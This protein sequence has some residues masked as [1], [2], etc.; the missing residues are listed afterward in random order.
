MSA[1]SLSQTVAGWRSRHEILFLTILA[2]V[3]TAVY[4][5]MDVLTLH[6]YIVAT[7]GLTAVFAYLIVGSWTGTI[8]GVV[9]AY[10][11]GK[12]LVD[13]DF[14]GMIFRNR[15]MHTSAAVAGL[16][17]SVSTL[18]FLWGS[19]LGDPG[20]VIALGNL[21]I[22]NTAIWDWHRKQVSLRTI[23]LPLALSVLGGG[24]AVYGGSMQAGLLAVLF[25]V[26]IS[27]GLGTISEIVEQ[28]G[29]R[30]SD[31]VNFFIWR[32][33][34]L[35]LTGTSLAFIVSIT[36]GTLPLLIAT[37]GQATTV[38]PW[39]AL[40]MLFVFM[41]ISLKL[42]AKK[43]GAISIVLIVMSVQVILGYVFT[44]IGNLVQPGLFGQLP[45]DPVVWL[46]RIAGGVLI[47]WGI[48]CIKKV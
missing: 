8:C 10:G 2:A 1:L 14:N 17:S 27:N 29:T 20:V 46:V 4:R 12:R 18:F 42:T 5:M 36:R 41:G 22:V 31:G 32:F 30:A 44:F 3:F 23:A 24:M 26:V 15:K 37:L 6:N 35:A 48:F 25:I 28:H 40:T 39:I 9:F 34:W 38:L 43:K 11:W 21:I 33:A 13:S 19:Q 47:I 45:S 16:I 7:D